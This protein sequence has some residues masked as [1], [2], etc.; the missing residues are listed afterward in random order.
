M[1]DLSDRRN[2]L[3][4]QGSSILQS[5]GVL[6][7]YIE[8]DK[9]CYTKEKKLE[10]RARYRYQIDFLYPKTKKNVIQVAWMFSIVY[11]DVLLNPEN[12]V[13]QS[14]PFVK[15]PPHQMSSKMVRLSQVF[16]DH[17]LSARFLSYAKKTPGL[18]K[19]SVIQLASR[20]EHSCF[21]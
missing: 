15:Y 8:R 12:Y 2:R 10:S 21:T 6:I 18:I 11:Y 20:G 19:Y 17:Q 16:E 9:I 1:L 13:E 7:L 5:T 14:I 4:I 3:N